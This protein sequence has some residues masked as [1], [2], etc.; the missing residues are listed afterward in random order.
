MGASK[1][2]CGATL[3]GPYGGPLRA[4]VRQPLRAPIGGPLK[5]PVGGPQRGIEFALRP[6]KLRVGYREALDMYSTALGHRGPPECPLEG[7]LGGPLP[8]VC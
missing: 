4:P 5:A 8:T 2:S 1:V 3:K 7:P 6:L